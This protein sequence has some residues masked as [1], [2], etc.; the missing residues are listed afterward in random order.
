MSC[1]PA[2]GRANQCDGSARLSW[3]VSLPPRTADPHCPA[4]HSCNRIRFHCTGRKLLVLTCIAWQ[5]VSRPSAMGSTCSTVLW[6]VDRQTPCST[7]HTDCCTLRA[8]DRVWSRICL[9]LARAC[10]T[11]IARTWRRMQACQSTASSGPLTSRWS[12]FDCQCPHAPRQAST[13]ASSSSN[14]RGRGAVH[15]TRTH[16]TRH[17]H[18]R[19]TTLLV[20]HVSRP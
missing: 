18:R 10:H 15:S 8:R 7:C 9:M 12:L 5:I 16:S 14:W 19:W 17:L 2:R 11:R 1:W 3:P 20:C 6:W 13:S 4:C